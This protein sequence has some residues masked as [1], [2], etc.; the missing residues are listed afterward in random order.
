S[1]GIQLGARYDASPLI[2]GDGTEPPPDSPVDYVPSA[3]PGGRAPHVWLDDG[4]SIHDRFGKWFTLVKFGAPDTDM[5]PF[6]AAAAAL[7]V[8]LDV[9]DVAEPAARAL[10]QCAFALIRPDHHVAWRGDALPDDAGALMRQVSGN[11]L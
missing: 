8:P 9:I 5:S 2:V 10:Y 7:N 4:A 11:M 6:E 1:L 3:C